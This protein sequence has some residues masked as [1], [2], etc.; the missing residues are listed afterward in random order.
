MTAEPQ[1]ERL[2]E[3]IELRVSG[4]MKRDL[5]V[6]A[7]AVGLTTGE[8]IRRAVAGS[9]SEAQG[10]RGYEQAGPAPVASA[11]T[12]GARP[13]ASSRAHART[14]TP[15]MSCGEPRDRVPDLSDRPFNVNLNDPTDIYDKLVEARGIL[16]EYETS[17]T[18]LQRIERLVDTWRG[19][20]SFL[21]SRIPEEP[22]QPTHVADPQQPGAALLIGDLVVEV[23]ERENRK[24]RSKD[25]RAA[26][27]ADGHSFTGNQVSNAL[28]YQAI[29]AKPPRIRTASGRGM[30]A[31]LDFQDG[32]FS[33][34]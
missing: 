19:N 3:R 8:L 31:P 6:K 15:C 30:Y 27:L 16:A 34:R 13:A 9:L 32:S 7:E 10:E 11:A 14:S 24:I 17:L 12:D 18:D 26:L 25:V 22:R 1:A 20:V 5:A 2:T 23:V 33:G 4:E 21:E 29:T 28:Y